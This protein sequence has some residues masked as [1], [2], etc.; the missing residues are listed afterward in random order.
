METTERM[1]GIKFGMGFVYCLFDIYNNVH[2]IGQTSDIPTNRNKK[3]YSTGMLYPLKYE[4]SI[5]I[6]NYTEIEKK[7]HKILENF[8]VSSNREFFNINKEVILQLFNKFNIDG[9]KIIYQNDID[10]YNLINKQS[11]KRNF[12]EINDI[13]MI[14]ANTE[15]DK[16]TKKP[17]KIKKLKTYFKN[18]QKIR[19]CIDNNIWIG[20]YDYDNDKIIYQ[21]I[22][23]STITKFATAHYKTTPCKKNNC[24]S[25]W[26]E[27][28]YYQNGNWISTSLL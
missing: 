11:K 2:K 27:C 20:F 24:Y 28:E 16:I 19:H 18:G 6:K 1:K 13:E 7:I 22:K 4:F 5:Y 21:G 17:R 26:K 8:R 10:N 12:D 15:Y 9:N 3:L 25:G 14:D 23:Y